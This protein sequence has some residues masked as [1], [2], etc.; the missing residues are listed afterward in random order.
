MSDK[1]ALDAAV[2][3]GGVAPILHGLVADP[4]GR[5]AID[6]LLA[7]FDALSVQDHRPLVG[8]LEADGLAATVDE[9]RAAYTARSYHAGLALLTL[10]S[11]AL[12]RERATLGRRGTDAVA[13]PLIA[14]LPLTSTY[15]TLW[16]LEAKAAYGA[17]DIGAFGLIRGEASAASLYAFRLGCSAARDV[18][19]SELIGYPRLLSRVQ[20]LDLT[21]AFRG[22]ADRVEGPSLGLAAA[23]SAYSVMTGLRIPEDVAA[24]GSI[25]G[26]HGQVGEVGGLRE[27]HQACERAGVSRLLAWKGAIDTCQLSGMSC[28]VIELQSVRDAIDRIWPGRTPS[29]LISE[30]WSDAGAAA[31]APRPAPWDSEKEYVMV[32][33]LVQRSDPI[34]FAS[35]GERGAS[36]LTSAEAGCALTLQAECRPQMMACI[37]TEGEMAKRFEEIVDIL[38]A[39]DWPEGAENTAPFV[40]GVAV[41]NADLPDPSEPQAVMTVYWQ[42][43]SQVLAEGKARAAAAGKPLRVVANVSGGTPQMAYAVQRL[44]IK[45][46][47]VPWTLVQVRRS[48]D[49]K[50]GGHRVRVVAVP[51]EEGE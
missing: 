31:V 3:A 33:T 11:Q 44:S 32:L 10:V 34:G 5:D 2:R 38:P 49:I 36:S 23:V 19:V 47:E 40:L 18:L 26:L 25:I 4:F 7:A 39:A 30:R 15:A 51:I 43:I 14:P 21:G 1:S 9:L 6:G 41:R 35:A 12:E 20:R 42:L 50:D 22:L 27:K 46:Q 28:R 8:R 13:V 45:F 29:V 24:T 17:G 48:D 16:R 37:Y